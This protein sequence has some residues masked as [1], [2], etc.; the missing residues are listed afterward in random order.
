VGWEHVPLQNPGAVPTCAQVL[1]MYTSPRIRCCVR[2]PSNLLILY[3][4]EKPAVTRHRWIR[5]KD[6]RRRYRATCSSA[7][8]SPLT[9][10]TSYLLVILNF[11]RHGH[12]E[13][14]FRASLVIDIE[15]MQ[16]LVSQICPVWFWD[17]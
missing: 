5:G 9:K 6:A 14:G 13:H 1:A 8:I 16:S 10:F 2:W 15:S 17:Q 4:F 7:S 11:L 3:G 12:S